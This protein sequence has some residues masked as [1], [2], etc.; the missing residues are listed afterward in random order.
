MKKIVLCLCAL[1]LCGCQNN[2]QVVP[3]KEATSSDN[4]DTS[5]KNNTEITGTIPE[6][7]YFMEDHGV[8]KLNGDAVSH[9]QKADII[10]WLANLKLKPTHKYDD[11]LIIDENSVAFV[12]TEKKVLSAKID[13][14]YGDQRF[15]IYWDH[16]GGGI[17]ILKFKDSLNIYKV[18]CF[19]LENGL[20]KRDK[21]LDVSSLGEVYQPDFTI[22]EDV[23]VSKQFLDENI[24]NINVDLKY[25]KI[26]LWGISNL[27]KDEKDKQIEQLLLAFYADQQD[28]IYKMQ[29]VFNLIEPIAKGNN[30]MDMINEINIDGK[31]LHLSEEVPDYSRFYS[32]EAVRLKYEE[33][34][35]H[36]LGDI[37]N[38]PYFGLGYRIEPEHD[39]FIYYIYG[40][41]ASMGI[42]YDVP[43]AYDVRISGNEMI[44]KAASIKTSFSYI[45]GNT[46]VYKNSGIPLGYRHF[47]DASKTDNILTMS[48]VIKDQKDNLDLYVIYGQLNQWGT[49]SLMGYDN[50]TKTS[51]PEKDVIFYNLFERKDQKTIFL[52]LFDSNL[53]RS[54]NETILYSLSRESKYCDD[55]AFY[56][57][58]HYAVIYARDWM[59]NNLVTY[60]LDKQNKTFNE[61]M[62]QDEA[63]VY[64]QQLKDANPHLKADTEMILYTANG[65]KLLYLKGNDY[66]QD[67]VIALK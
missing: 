17:Q 58:E 47:S 29:I 24:A 44:I 13:V 67:I 39:L 10:D 54:A 50:Q 21:S 26:A 48:E 36:Q 23:K 15:A 63:D 41:A 61:P 37:P 49:Y 66:T 35:G 59:K 33:L 20:F 4:A 64:Y 12:P 11:R 28:F 18:D 3:Q 62:S 14:E 9:K 55:Y 46:N 27:S 25:P 30:S 38:E 43:Y 16:S 51:L 45:D 32:G 31:T 57:D 40:D 34:F 52:P 1:C 60:V 8:M 65:Q 7:E 53:A 5:S 56:E 6:A 19:E 42:T 2:N 22:P